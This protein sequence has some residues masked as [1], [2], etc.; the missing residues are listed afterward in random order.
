MIVCPRLVVIRCHGNQTAKRI[1][2]YFV[3]PQKPYALCGLDFVEIFIIL[4]FTDFVLFFFMK[5][6][7]LVWLNNATSSK[8]VN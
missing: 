3:S 6:I 2:K 5:I 7:G 4:A 8:G 1:K